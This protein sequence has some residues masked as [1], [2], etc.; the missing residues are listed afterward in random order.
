ME[1][2][3]TQPPGH[4]LEVWHRT[5]GR[6]ADLRLE[7]GRPVT[8]GRSSAMSIVLGDHRCS[9]RHLSI[10]LGEDDAVYI[11][12]TS[13]NGTFLNGAK[14][15]KHRPTCLKDG[16]CISPVVNTH[17]HKPSEMN[18]AMWGMIIVQLFYHEPASR[19]RPTPAALVAEATTEAPPSPSPC[20][21]RPDDGAA[22]CAQPQVSAA[23]AAGAD[24]RLLS[25]IHI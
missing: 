12:D 8:L 3:P 24:L 23:A 25:L 10:V 20:G 2:T 17:R 14:L 19:A 6:A 4:V 7:C 9:S 11:T 15:E 16:D 1:A 22:A 5:S 18:E 21:P 13:T